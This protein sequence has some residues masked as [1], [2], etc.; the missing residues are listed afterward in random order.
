MPSFLLVALPS[1]VV[2]LEG[3]VSSLAKDIVWAGNVYIHEVG[4]MFDPS[5]MSFDWSQM[6]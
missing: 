5:W 1:L 2:D 4:V 6:S 3:E